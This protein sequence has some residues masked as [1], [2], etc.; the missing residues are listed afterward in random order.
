MM[1]TAQLFTGYTVFCLAVPLLLKPP[2]LVGGYRLS[3][4]LVV[5]VA[6]GA[7]F[8]IGLLSVEDLIEMAET[9]WR[10]V[11]TLAALMTLGYATERLGILAAMARLV[12]WGAAPSA[13]ALFSRVFSL[14]ILSSILLNNDTTIIMVTPLALAIVRR[15]YPQRPDLWEPFAYAVF[16]AAGVAPFM[17]SNPMNLVVASMAGI[18]FNE[19]ARVMLPVAL[20]VWIV[21]FIVLRFAVARRLASAP[22]SRSGVD[23]SASEM[24]YWPMAA[25]LIAVV[26][27]Y[28]IGALYHY[29]VWLIATSGA[30]L[31]CLLLRWRAQVT[32][33]QAMRHG[34]SWETLL[35][36]IGVV[37]VGLGLRNAGI[38]DALTRL[39]THQ[40][41]LV[42]GLFSALS[43][44]VANNHPMAILNLLAL[45][46]EQ[47]K[48]VDILAALIGGDLGPRFLPIGSL[49][50][51]MWV[52]LLRR[53]QA[54]FSLARFVSLGLLINVPT[55]LVALIVLDMLI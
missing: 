15:H 46:G 8:L 36:L 50:G 40:S 3:P 26:C 48:T 49:A 13:V 25:L 55:L 12:S 18:G 9:L 7:Y 11:A 37:L 4:A 5:A 45:G 16:I 1:S 43:S 10:P 35:F 14:A 29:P 41:P 54:D 27:A 20:S 23:D 33:T 30:L 47:A 53:H 2:R 42:I 38:T 51:L 39:Y 17:I 19:Y 31:A 6:V 32:V 28:P 24:P 21:S 22:T 52:A 44:A 34:I